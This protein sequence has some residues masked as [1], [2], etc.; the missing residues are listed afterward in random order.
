MKLKQRHFADSVEFEFGDD[1]FDYTI[2]SSGSKKRF[3]V[4]YMRFDPEVIEEIEQANTWWRN[5]GVAWVVIGVFLTGLRYANGGELSLSFWLYLG[6][7]CLAVY[8]LGRTSFLSHAIEGGGRILLIKDGRA[9]AILEEL[10][11]RRRTRLAKVFG[12]VDPD[13]DPEVEVAKLKW[14]EG[15]G[16][17]S[18]EDVAAKISEIRAA[19]NEGQEDPTQR[20]N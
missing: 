2:K 19:E 11:E 15:Q 20:V 7:V 16:A 17:L 12:E 9:P 14:L 13:E 8:R 1:E 3:S 18:S 4:D 10:T 5:A 6:I